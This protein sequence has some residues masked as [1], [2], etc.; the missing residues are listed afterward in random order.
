MVL[1][2]LPDALRD[3]D[4]IQAIIRGTAMNQDG[5][6]PG[7]TNPSSDAQERLMRASYENAGIITL[8]TG[9][10]EAHGTGTLVGDPIETRAIANVFGRGRGVSSPVMLG[11]VK[12]NIGHLEAASGLASLIKA[13]MI[14]KKGHTP[15]NLNFSSPN[16]HIPF[17]EWGLKV[18]CSLFPSRISEFKPPMF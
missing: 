13:A 17:E 3:G 9:Y 11:S 1:K 10:I 14:F 5:S 8:E 6:T 12:T 2:L 16:P 7:I 15:P 18:R 4:P